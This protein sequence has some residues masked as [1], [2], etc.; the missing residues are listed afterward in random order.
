[1]SIAKRT[2][3]ADDGQLE[4]VLKDLANLELV[5]RKVLGDRKN[6]AN[7][8]KN[9]PDNRDVLKKAEPLERVIEISSG[10]E[11]SVPPP[12]VAPKAE[13]LTRLTKAVSKA[14]DN[15]A[16]SQLVTEFVAVLQSNTARSLTKEGFAFLKALQKQLTDL[17]IF[18]LPRRTTRTRSDDK[19][20][21]ASSS[22]EGKLGVI[23]RLKEEVCTARGN[24][25][26]A[27]MVGEFEGVSLMRTGRTVTKDGF[28]FLTGLA[29]TLQKI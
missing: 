25:E 17:S 18:I 21:L 16:I 26:L 13:R 4:N 15:K 22:K 2:P 28:A 19:E 1:V 5:D 7:A 12:V 29:E 11:G 14:T 27:N 20:Q 8:V 10:S 23:A 24:D 9:E 6:I 3:V